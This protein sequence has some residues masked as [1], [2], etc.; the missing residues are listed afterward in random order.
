MSIQTITAFL[1]ADHRRLEALL[2]AA[3]ATA[4]A[5]STAI[6]AAP[7]A[8]FRR[9]LLRHIA[10]EEKLLLPA[11]QAARG[12]EPLPIAERLRLDHGAIAA[13]LVPTPTA[14]IVATLRHILER[15]DEIEEGP[16]GLYATCDDLLARGVDALLAKM[17]A[18]PEPPVNAHNDGPVVMP[19]VRR[20]LERAGYRL[21]A[22]AAPGGRGAQS[23]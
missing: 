17:R 18:Y 9:G 19:A 7:Y 15:H 2:D 21:V 8:E 12:G 13:L 23:G 5:P 20:A 4:A 14:E 10:I 1:I 11:A 3:T 16:G 6:D 22:P